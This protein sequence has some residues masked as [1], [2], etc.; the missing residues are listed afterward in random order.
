L[1]SRR[2][3]SR[4]MRIRPCIAALT[5]IVLTAGVGP[6]AEPVFRTKVTATQAGDRVKIAFA[7]SAPTDVEVAVLDAK[8]K[9]VRHLAA[10]VLGGKNPPPAPLQPGLA[11]EIVWDGKDD[12]GQK[13]EGPFQLRARAGTGIVLGRILADIPYNLNQ[14]MCRGLA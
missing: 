8:G 5:F 3:G 4:A 6:G 7:V 9:V 1:N 13:A 12:H 10:G 2:Q 11:Q 14:T